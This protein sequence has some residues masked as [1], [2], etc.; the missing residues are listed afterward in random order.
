M[1]SKI[2]LDKDKK[3]FKFKRTYNYM[4]SISELILKR[5]DCTMT[6]LQNPEIFLYFVYYSKSILAAK[7]SSNS[8]SFELLRSVK[9]F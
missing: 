4:M 9:R 8:I 2:V 6:F 3:G 1:Y 7:I 5:C